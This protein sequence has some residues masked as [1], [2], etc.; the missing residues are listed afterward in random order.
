MLD[1]LDLVEAQR[2]SWRPSGGFG[3]RDF[4]EWSLD[5]NQSLIFEI[6]GPQKVVQGLAGSCHRGKRNCLEGQHGKHGQHHGSTQQL[7]VNFN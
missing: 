2:I 6:Q 7:N 1:M 3:P 5:R 4:C